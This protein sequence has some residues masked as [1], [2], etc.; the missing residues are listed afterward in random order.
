MHCM[1]RTAVYA[2]P[3]DTAARSTARLVKKGE[4]WFL[5]SRRLAVFLCVRWVGWIVRAAD[6]GENVTSCDAWETWFG[7]SWRNTE[8]MAFGRNFVLYNPILWRTAVS[9][10]PCVTVHLT[11]RN[12]TIMTRQGTWLCDAG[13]EIGWAWV[14]SPQVKHKKNWIFCITFCNDDI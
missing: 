7:F 13:R 4:I 6:G 5:L 2:W 10:D 3:W 8:M 9:S 11:T 1:S 12:K 14:L